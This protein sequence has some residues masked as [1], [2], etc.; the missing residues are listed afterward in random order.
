MHCCALMLIIKCQQDLCGAVA[1]DTWHL[2][3]MCR[4]ECQSTSSCCSRSGQL[5]Q[6]NACNGTQLAATWVQGAMEHKH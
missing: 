2:K 6:Y 1:C 5:W 4:V 3:R